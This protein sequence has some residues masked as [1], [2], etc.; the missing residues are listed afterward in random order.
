MSEKIPIVLASGS[1][2]RRGLLDA[3]GVAFEV[4]PANVDEAALRERYF[5]GEPFVSPAGAAEMLAH[6]KARAVSAIRPDA[7]VIGSDQVL[8][9]DGDSRRS[10]A[11]ILLVSKANTIEKARE[12]LVALRGRRHTLHSAVAVQG[13]ESTSWSHVAEAHLTMRDFSDEFLENYLALEGDGILS[14]VG[15]YKI[16]G[17][18]AQLF[19]KIEGD[20]STILGMPLF[21]L[22]SELRRRG[23]IPS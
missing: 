11:D 9:G 14:S 22:L 13:G 10:N 12:I 5:V 15:C 6:A 18:G 7:I 4:A 21:P 1:A 2:A 8:S 17:R 16:E 3:A 23:A 20:H 19:E